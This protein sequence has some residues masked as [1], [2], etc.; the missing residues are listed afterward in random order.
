M[1]NL[2]FKKTTMYRYEI[3]N[4]IYQNWFYLIIRMLRDLN[5]HLY[6]KILQIMVDSCHKSS[7]NNRWLL[8]FGQMLDKIDSFYYY[9]FK[10][11][12]SPWPAIS[13]VKARCANVFFYQVLEPMCF[14]S[15]FFLQLL[16]VT[17]WYWF[18][19]ETSE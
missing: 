3:S 13:V 2:R 4:N 6:R 1:N 19:M 17:S 16:L 15:W 14:T 10:T 7:K 18:W 11:L 12:L 9:L 5:K 8:T